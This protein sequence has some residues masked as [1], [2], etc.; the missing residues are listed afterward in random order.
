M[1]REV[2]RVPLDFGWP[3]KK[4]WGGYFTPEF[5]HEE[6]CPDCT[7]GWSERGQ[8]LH[9]LWY[10]H[11][12]FKPEDNGS[13]PFTTDHPYVRGRAE[14]NV[15]HSPDFYGTGERAIALE[16]FRLAQ[17][18]NG[19]WM[20]HLNQQDVDALVEG[21]RLYD[22]T[23]TVVKGEG[24]VPK[25]PPYHPTAAEV[26]DW[27]LEGFGHDGLNA[28]VV[29]KARCTLEGVSDTCETCGGHGSLEAWPGQRTCSEA[30]HWWDPP[31]GD[32]WQLWETTSEGSPVSPVFPTAEE[33]AQW[34]TTDEGGYQL[35]FGHSKAELTYEQALKFVGA[36]WAPSMI[37]SP[38][39]G[40]ETGV[41]AVVRMAE[42]K[43]ST[44]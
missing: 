14:R 10:G 42:E 18:Y 44:E 41:E 34:L 33:L 15:N 27:S 12:P 29:I 11:V 20:H 24:W 40:L 6:D 23:H 21:G 43:E 26:N 39:H 31:E 32:G 38:E 19:S 1:S 2:R 9:D 30:W 17:I 35:G 25:D 37:T 36:G 16:A 5:L 22:F 13:T 28:H 4:V 3:L 7:G 8:Y